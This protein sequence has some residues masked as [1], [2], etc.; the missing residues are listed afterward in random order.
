MYTY[1]IAYRLCSFKV[2]TQLHTIYYLHL[3]LYASINTF[4]INANNAED[5][6]KK[7]HKN[8]SIT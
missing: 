7:S 1:D 8:K 6:K 4:K 3:F 5:T 2:H